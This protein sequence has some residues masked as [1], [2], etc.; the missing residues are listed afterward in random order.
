MGEIKVIEVLY[1]IEVIINLKLTVITMFY[2]IPMETT[3]KI[4]LKD[5]Q[6][7]RKNS[8]IIYNN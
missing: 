8:P 3:K 6:K 1:M 4:P 5:V 7:K 2:L